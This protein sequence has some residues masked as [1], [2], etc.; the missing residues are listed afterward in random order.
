MALKIQ[1]KLTIAVSL[2]LACLLAFTA[3]LT[4][5]RFRDA[6][7]TEIFDKQYAMLASVAEELDTR[8]ATAH[9]LLISAANDFPLDAL[10]DPDRVQAILDRRDD[11]HGVFDNHV[12]V[13]TP[14]GLLYTESPYAPGRRGKDYAFREY[15]RQT[16]ATGK[17][18][19]SDPYISSQAHRH[20]VIMMT[21]PIRDRDGRLL[22]IL[23][24]SHD[25]MRDNFLGKLVNRRVG[26]SGYFYLTTGDRV[27]VMHPDKQ[28]IFKPVP[29]G[30]NLAYDRAVG[31]FQGS[32]ETI[33]TYGRHMYASFK[34]LGRKDWILAVNYPVTEALAPL[35]AFQWRILLLALLGLA[36][37]ALLIHVLMGRLLR[38]M[39]TLTRHMDELPGKQ[40]DARLLPVAGGDETAGLTRA[41]NAMVRTLDRQQAALEEKEALYRTVVRFATDFV[42]WRDQD[43]GMRYVSEHSA[44]VTGHP[45]E[46]FYANPALLDEIVHPDDREAWCQHVHDIGQHGEVN[47]LEMRI[48]TPDGGVRWI[49]HQCQ[50]VVDEHGRNLGIRG[51]H[52]DITARKQ[53]EARLRLAGTV[54]DSAR[55]AILVTDAERRLV[56]VNPAFTRMTGYAESEVTGRDP[57]L[58]QSG[59]MPADHYREMWRNLERHGHWQGEFANKRKDGTL[60]NVLAAIS[61]VRDE[62]GRLTH[63]VG[64]ESDIT[65]MKE[66]ENRIEHLAYHD[67]LTG[68]PNRALLM[69]RARLA[70][71]LA[72]RRQEQAA[73]LFLDLDRFKEVNDSLGHAAGDALLVEAGRRLGDLVRATDTVS[74]LGGDEFVLMLLGVGQHGAGEVSEKI[75][76]AMRE[77][78]DVEGHSL[79]LSTSIGI[80][81][82]PR[83]GLDIGE[84]LKNAD[85]ALYRAKQE[86]RNLYVF[87]DRGMNVATFEKLV[88]ESELRQAIGGDELITHYQPKVHLES[89][90]LL[91]AEALVRWRHPQHGLVPPGRFIPVAETSGL[92]NDLCRWVLDDVCGQL[93]EWK[94]QGLPL[95][96]VS[97][98]LSPRNFRSPLLTER[99]NGL[100]AGHDLPASA[101]ELELT[102]STLLESGQQVVENL[103]AIKR[104]GIGLAIDDFGTGYSSLSYLRRLPISVLKIDRS[105]VCDLETNQEDRALAGSIIALGNSL[106][107]GVIAEGVETFAQRDILLELGCK[108]GQG[109]LYSRPLPA[110]EFRDWLARGG[111][112]EAHPPAAGANRA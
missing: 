18:Y 56:V 76:A 73:I 70:M 105:F 61:A 36:F 64:I 90:R 37:S 58:L 27:L 60:F 99:L 82:F 39:L 43:G 109:Y 86:G 13:F 72:H 30:G 104:M 42:F 2:L 11:L 19:I 21:A 111:M 69:E 98:N 80:A 46:D 100:L 102:E 7:V 94:R 96:P 17:P 77:P 83:D 22:A 110:E 47:H 23:A 97:I 9:N 32:M 14:E 35:R 92:I 67:P 29:A 101:L 79:A 106:G 5:I 33:N 10:D 24:A 28:R 12:F 20:P 38:P 6:L 81:L 45:P 91:G 88:L 3:V 48:V 50:L 85:T 95:V 59:L 55:E 52:T 15:I 65:A 53:S 62:A 4:V 71:A 41:F 87:Y 49:S 1:T 84:L 66:A 54:F 16:L 57:S 63:Y 74:R 75:L 103:L 93:D 8:L 31:G 34:R 78:F 112:P 89:G 44:R 25:L 108:A 51:R 26:G 107:L 68:L 40:G